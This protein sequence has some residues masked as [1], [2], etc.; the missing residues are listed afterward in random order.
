M[1]GFYSRGR[2]GS[3]KDRCVPRGFG[4]SCLVRLDPIA[5]V[6]VAT[7]LGGCAG[8]VTFPNV[9]PGN[10]VE[11]R[12]QLY[13]PEGPGP[14]PA[15]VL[16]H[17]CAGVEPHHARWARWLTERGYVALVVDSWGSRGIVENCSKGTPDVENTD[18]FDDAF[19]GLRYLQSLAY[20]DPGRIGAVG[21]SNGGVFSMAVVNGPSLERA[22]KRGVTLPAVRFR[23]GIGMS[24][25]GCF[26]LVREVVVAPLLVLIGAADDWTLA[27][28]CEEMV[29]AMRAKGADA[30]IRIFPGAYH[31]FDNA[32]YPLQVLPDVEN[33]NRPGGC[34]GATVGYQ[35]EAAAA[36]AADVEA[37]LAKH[38]NPNFRFE[39]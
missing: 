3:T 23:L 30:T 2:G 32:D 4:Y 14:F 8:S 33:R 9:T 16:L 28:T 31:Y 25:G 5:G 38:L 39:R 6:L 22:R 15:M 34:C 12:G 7:L 26:S 18:R 24:P 29:K 37:F 1:S 36:A 13:R 20:V 27:T 19:G 10:Q 17:G 11:V 35:P 21:W